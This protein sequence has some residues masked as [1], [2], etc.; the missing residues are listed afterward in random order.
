[1]KTH[2]AAW[3]GQI[4]WLAGWRAAVIKQKIATVPLT[5][6]LFSLR[7]DTILEILWGFIPIHTISV[8]RFTIQG[9]KFMWLDMQMDGVTVTSPT[10]L[11]TLCL[12]AWSLAS[13]WICQELF[14]YSVTYRYATTINLRLAPVWLTQP[15]NQTVATP[16][17][18]FNFSIYSK[19]NKIIY[20]F[21]SFYNWRPFILNLYLWTPA[22]Q[23]IECTFFLH[24]CIGFQ[25]LDHLYLV[26]SAHNA[27]RSD[28]RDLRAHT[29]CAKKPTDSYS[30]AWRQGNCQ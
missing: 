20:L 1:M 17:I 7:H 11:Q 4:P 15:V 3:S 5:Q 30:L 10:G 24:F 18:L 22:G 19:L 12:Q 14:N 13:G 6:F 2:R 9:L 16:I 21:S 23:I 8:N 26:Y 28:G 25:F 29:I 27:V